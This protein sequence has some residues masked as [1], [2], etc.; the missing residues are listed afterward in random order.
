MNFFKGKNK[1]VSMA[2]A[3]ALLVGAVGAA[4]VSNNKSLKADNIEAKLMNSKN[5]RTTYTT[6]IVATKSGN[7]QLYITVLK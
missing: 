4:G 3:A 5:I 7:I 2:L 6:K 1:Y